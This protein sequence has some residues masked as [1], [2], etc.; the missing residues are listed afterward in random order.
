[1]P[2]KDGPRPTVV[3]TCVFPQVG[4]AS[5]EALLQDTLGMIDGMARQAEAQGWT[6]DLAVLPE[7][8]FQFLQHNVAELAQDLDGPFV[9]AVGEKAKQYGTYATA[10]IRHTGATA[11]CTIPW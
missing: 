11:K 1:M 5:P 8:S 10:P 7:C 6:L 9:R 4:A 2:R 3:G